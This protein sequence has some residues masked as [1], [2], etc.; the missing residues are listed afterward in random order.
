MEFATG[1]QREVYERIGGWLRDLYGDAVREVPE[2]P[3]YACSH[4]GTQVHVSVTPWGEDEATVTVRSGVVYDLR[5]TPEL[6]YYLLRGNE[7]LRFGAFALDAANDVVVGHTIVGSTCDLA[8][9][10]ASV[11]G[12]AQA[13]ARY[14]P[15]IIQRFGGVTAEDHWASRV[16]P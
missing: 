6:T 10:R 14:A 15:R 4:D 9:L 5:I 11:Q 8:E 16:G 7:L 12:V 1:V 2:L 3:A 13:A